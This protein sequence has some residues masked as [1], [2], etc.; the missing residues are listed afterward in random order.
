MFPSDARIL[1]V[2]DL[3]SVREQILLVLRNMGYKNV[4]EAA[5]GAEAQKLLAATRVYGR[6]FDLILCDWNM[7]NVTGYDILVY[8]R[9]FDEFKDCAFVMISTESERE[10]VIHAIQAGLDHYLLKPVSEGA[11]VKALKAVWKRKN[12]KS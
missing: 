8:V 11:F 6:P 3:Q 1:V 4:T 12:G 10:R 7:P 2:E 5:D 9:T